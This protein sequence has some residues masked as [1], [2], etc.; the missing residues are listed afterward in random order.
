[1]TDEVLG[2]DIGTTHTKCCL[3]T[4]GEFKYESS[5]HNGYQEAGE[6]SMY[7]HKEQNIGALVRSLDDCLSKFG[8]NLKVSRFVV[9]GQMHGIVSW[10]PKIMEII[11]HET[12]T[13]LMNGCVKKHSN[14]ITWEDQRCDEEFLKSFPKSRCGNG[15]STGYG[16]AS[17]LWLQEAGKLEDYTMC[18]TIMD[19]IVWLLTQTERVYM[20]PHNAKSWGYFDEELM[21]WES[22]IFSGKIDPSLLPT[23]LPVQQP[24]GMATV[25]CHGI[26]K[27]HTVVYGALGDMQCAVRS[28]RPKGNEAVLNIGTSAQLSIIVDKDSSMVHQTISQNHS[29]LQIVPY[30]QENVIVT[31]ASLNG[32]NVLHQLATSLVSWMT[33]LECQNV[34]SSS[35]VLIKFN[36]LQTD[37]GTSL[38]E[39]SP[40]IF[41]ERHDPNLSA[42]VRNI[43]PDNLS[44]GNIVAG[45]SRGIIE[46]MFRMMPLDFRRKH[47]VQRIVG[48]GGALRASKM[49]RG[50]VVE[51]SGLELRMAEDTDASLGSIL[52]VQQD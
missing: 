42:S 31:A 17:L 41:G 3:F 29:E 36:Q 24:I 27:N 47:D 49:L 11:N 46:N 19:F 9:T 50:Y 2:I 26:T 7:T 43:R 40:T 12:L 15:V 10:K 45:M 25:S 6:L 35:E 1:M 33:D 13:S 28:C 20:T 48:T 16:L 38:L 5:L 8:N 52:F 39:I 51:I 34:P 21:A 37:A 44:L 18:G 23:V 14:L 30:D 22:E 32:G 4:D